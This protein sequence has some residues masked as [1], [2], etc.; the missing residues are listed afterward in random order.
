MDTGTFKKNFEYKVAIPERC[1]NCRNTEVRVISKGPS[2]RVAIICTHPERDE[3][4]E[5]DVYGY[6]TGYLVDN[7]E[8]NDT[9][10]E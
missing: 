1:S 5:V 10:Q 8:V 6:C 9:W 3:K 4:T 2:P 7:R